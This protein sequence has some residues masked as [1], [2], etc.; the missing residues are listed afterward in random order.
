MHNI[1]YKSQI[2][3]HKSLALAKVRSLI[4]AGASYLNLSSKYKGK[5]NMIHNI[6][7]IGHK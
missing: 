2:R 1:D 4:L 7:H 5:H 3:G 6:G